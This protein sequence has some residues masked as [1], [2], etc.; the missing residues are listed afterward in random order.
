MFSEHELSA[1]HCAKHD[2]CAKHFMPSCNT[3][4]SREGYYYY[5]NFTEEKTEEQRATSNLQCTFMQTR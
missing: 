5:L 1:R 4:S 3:R 2:T